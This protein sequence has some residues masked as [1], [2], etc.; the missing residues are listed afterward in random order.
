YPHYIYFYTMLAYIYYIS[1]NN[2]RALSVLNGLSGLYTDYLYVSHPD[3]I[4]ILHALF[5]KSCILYNLNERQKALSSL[6]KI[7]SLVDNKIPID[8]PVRRDKRIVSLKYIESITLHNMGIVSMELDKKTEALSYLNNATMLT[9][10]L[11]GRRDFFMI[12]SICRQST[13]TH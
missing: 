13:D 3:N 11:K 4:D 12:F 2:D 8:N 5:L 1:G 9:P 7:L 6:S 10:Q